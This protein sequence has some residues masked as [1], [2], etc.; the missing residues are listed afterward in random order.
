MMD[1]RTARVVDDGTNALTT[2]Y[3]MT[4]STLPPPLP[5]T[6]SSWECANFIPSKAVECGGLH[7][8]CSATHRATLY[9]AA[10]LQL[11]QGS[12]STGSAEG[13]VSALQRAQ[14][15]TCAQ[16]KTSTLRGALGALLEQRQRGAWRTRERKAAHRESAFTTLPEELATCILR[17]LSAKDL[18]R[19]SGTCRSWRAESTRV[20][21]EKL[22]ACRHGGPSLDGLNWLRALAA[23]EALAS[24]VGPRPK[25]AWWTEWAPM[26]V[27]EVL[28]TAQPERFAH[29]PLYER[30]GPMSVMAMLCRY[31]GGLSWMFDCGWPLHQAAACLLIGT[32]GT[33][34]LGMHLRSG[35]SRYAASTYA[36]CDALLARASTLRCAAPLTFASVDGLF[37]LGSTDPAWLAL[38]DEVRRTPPTR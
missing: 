10:A 14:S 8:G 5:S 16:Q 15:E 27:E 21:E 11:L 30:K 32:F 31:A 2:P 34:A 36:Y 17:Q 1:Q 25:H 38:N 20:A 7:G 37:G 22:R 23:E 9:T 4:A 19:A 28:L 3:L 35:S 26:R 33:A 24:A 13:L 18:A 29:A 6:S 12:L